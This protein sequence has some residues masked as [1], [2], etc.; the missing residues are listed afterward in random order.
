MKIM[1]RFA[2][3]LV[4]AVGLAGAAQAQIDRST[5]AEFWKNPEF[6]KQ[7]LGSYGFLPEVEPRITAD[8]QKLFKELIDLIQS[9]PDAAA[10]KLKAAIKS[11][12]SAALDFTLANLYVQLGRLDEAEK[13]YKAAL[14]KFPDF[15]R[16]HK[17]LGIVYVQRED[18]TNAAA[19]L[20]RTVELGGQDGNTYG[21]LGY[22]NL[23]Q[24][25]YI[26]AET[27]YRKALLMAPDNADWKLGL[28]RCLLAQQR[29]REAVALF[30]ELIQK[31]PEKPDYWLFQAN[32]YLDLSEHMKAADN[33]EI[34]RRM[35]KATGTVLMALGDIYVS[36]ESPDLALGAYLDSLQK[37]PKQDIKRPFHA[38]EVLVSRQAWKQAATLLDRI[39][40]TYGDALHDQDKLKILKLKS[41]VALATGDDQEAVR[42]LQDIINR[43]PLDGEALLILAGYYGRSD[44]PE[45]AEMLYER[46]EKLKDH[47]VNA[48]TAHAQL[49]VAQSKYDKAVKLLQRAQEL[50]PRDAVAKYL[51]QVQYLARASRY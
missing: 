35:G 22:C 31:D 24:G 39:N 30:D 28:A 12:S 49:L 33:Y 37:E 19:E 7:F 40:T 29:S 51:E 11:D 45:R 4:V 46:A 43:D 27:A 8:E 36:V 41:R 23:V 47:E 26:S 16:A 34:L 5:A 13:H 38:A 14:K 3:L 21:L 20:S 32:A 42:V 6:V 25:D 18:Y 44:Q 48:L 17:N 15:R 2:R 9:N 10:N 50:R 1:K